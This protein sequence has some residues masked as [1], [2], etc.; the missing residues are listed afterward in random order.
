MCLL[1]SSNFDLEVSYAFLLNSTIYWPT[2]FDLICILISLLLGCL[3]FYKLCLQLLHHLFTNHAKRSINIHFLIFFS[4]FPRAAS[5]ICSQKKK[6]MKRARREQ[7]ESNERVK[8]A[9]SQ[10]FKSRINF[11]SVPKGVT[12]M[13]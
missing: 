10:K 6:S 3:E 1:N 8:L 11:S 13:T 4:F 2:I 12:M 9:I 7:R 5:T